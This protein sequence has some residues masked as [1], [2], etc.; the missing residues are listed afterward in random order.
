MTSPLL[1]LPR[2]LRDNIYSYL[3]QDITFRDDYGYNKL[4]LEN[5]IAVTIQHAPLPHLLEVNWQLHKE[6]TESI[7]CSAHIA[8]DG[9]GM[10]RLE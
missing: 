10:A 6:Y 7:K 5:S 4:R 8:T 2:E 9:L 3:H 1:A